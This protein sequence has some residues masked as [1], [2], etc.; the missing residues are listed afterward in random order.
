MLVNNQFVFSWHC[1][2]YTFR[3]HSTNFL[4]TQAKK[5]NKSFFLKSTPMIG[6]LISCSYAY[7]KISHQTSL[8]PY[9]IKFTIFW[10]V[11]YCRFDGGVGK[12][13]TK[14]WVPIPFNCSQHDSIVWLFFSYL[15]AICS[16]VLPEKY[17]GKYVSENTSKNYVR[18]CPNSTDPYAP[19]AT[20]LDWP[21]APPP[22][23]GWV[24]RCM[25]CR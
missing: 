5:K 20:I 10:S 16:T 24:N 25:L 8:L 14:A 11:L 21:D 6:H 15:V 22:Y 17:C 3:Q 1:W 12:I 18:G 23:V 2:I 7:H 19:P 13:T 4:I 9:N